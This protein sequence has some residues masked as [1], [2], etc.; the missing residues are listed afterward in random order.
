MTTLQVFPTAA[1]R[2]KTSI[3]SFWIAGLVATLLAVTLGGCGTSQ[4]PRGVDSP[5]APQRET[6]A[7]EPAR[8]TTQQK[9]VTE[10]N[11][12]YPL[13]STDLG[14]Q[15]LRATEAL[16]T[17]APR[18]VYRDDNSR[19]YFSPNEA[20]AL[21]ED[22]RKKLASIELD[23]YRYY[24]T[25]YG[26]PLAYLRV[27]EL[28]SAHGLTEVPHTNILDFGYGSIGHLRLLA[29]LGAN[30]VGVD[31]D[32]YLDALYSQPVDQGSVSAARPVY[33]GA[34]GS[35]SLAH[36]LWPTTEAIAQKVT[37][38]GPYQLII[39][40]NTLKRGYLKPERR[41]PKNQLIELGVSDDVFLKAAYNALSPGGL[42][43]IYNLAPK[44]AAAD[45]PYLP[46]ADARSPF[47][48][49]QFSKA[50]LEVVALNVDDHGFV[51]QMGAAL[52]WDKNDQGEVVNDLSTNLF[53]IYT[54]VRR[55]K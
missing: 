9:L 33:R 49:E 38:K 2:A 18:T 32:S 43:V 20:A 6:P 7:A 46:H 51:R 23:E 48:A 8:S 53:A 29:S 41:A 37:S 55:S 36:G 14:K 19:E 5:P 40:K 4:T 30:V 17:V 22:R 50:G 45:K 27:I 42:F 15:F 25:K 47:S 24:Y 1:Q 34:A 21:S 52:G 10:A 26:S 31:P 44:K 16:P 13:A 54:I 12:L 28:A 3:D 39:S 35:V 11:A